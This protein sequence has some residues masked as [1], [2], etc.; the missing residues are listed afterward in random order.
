VEK[1]IDSLGV[2]LAAITFSA[3]FLSARAH[4]VLEAT[5]AA[6]TDRSWNVRQALLRGEPLGPVDIADLLAS[7]RRSA[8]PV[9]L[10]SRMVNFGIVL[11]STVILGSALWLLAHGVEHPEHARLLLVALWSTSVAVAVIGE[12]DLRRVRHDQGKAIRASTLGRL[13][14]LADALDRRDFPTA[15][16][17][18]DALKETYGAWGLLSELDAYLLLCTGRPEQGLATIR[19]LIET[20]EDL[21]VSAV[22]GVGCALALDEP[23]SARALLLAAADRQPEA[24]DIPLLRRSLS[25]S[26]GH[27]GALFADVAPDGATVR[28]SRA[29]G[30][31]AA[32]LIGAEVVG[33]DRRLTLDVPV[34]GVDETRRLVD[35]LRT[36]RTGSDPEALAGSAAGTPLHLALGLVLPST[37]ALPDADRLIDDVMTGTDGFTVE[38]LGMIH[39]MRGAA[40][41]AARAFERAT[42]LMPASAR[43]HWGMA[44]ACLHMGW[45]DRA[46]TSAMRAATLMP[47]RPAVWLVAEL[48]KGRPLPTVAEVGALFPYGPRAN[49]RA[50]LALL[51]FDLTGDGRAVTVHEQFAES[52][53]KTASRNAKTMVQRQTHVVQAR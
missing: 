1:H 36:W 28:R 50:E 13:E 19:H 35:I 20:N 38:G 5:V 18:L 7:V 39:L 17:H 44:L 3:G 53:I 10:A 42:H 31:A 15:Q 11:A 14:L 6:T 40:D 33:H 22:V 12:I 9:A 23:A 26:R 25:L 32:E 16:G 41:D 8:D 51:G 47:N 37:V 29:D 45:K 52:F 27:A 43:A 34:D 46:A 48:A 49:N 30:R 4:A 24:R 21:Y 2:L